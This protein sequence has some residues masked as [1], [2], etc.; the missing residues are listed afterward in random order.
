MGKGP[1]RLE[2]REQGIQDVV[3]GEEKM[4]PTTLDLAS[5]AFLLKAMGKNIVF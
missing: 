4:H 5:P 3:A 1:E 2:N